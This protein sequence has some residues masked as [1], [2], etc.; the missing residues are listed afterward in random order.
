V[1]GITV[2]V[3]VMT[4]VLWLTSA[5]VTRHRAESAA[6]LA[7]LSAA[8]LAVEGERR[9]CGEARWVAERMGVGLRSCHLS[10]WDVLVE[11]VV[12]P[13]GVPA[14]FGSAAARARA[15]PVERDR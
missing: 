3:V 6:D 2:V 10:G 9:A 15:G 12:V 4:G 8:G 13:S 14:N 7:A 11:V 5:V 1:G